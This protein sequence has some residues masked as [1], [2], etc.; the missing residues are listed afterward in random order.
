MVEEK[1]GPVNY[2]L[3]Q[4]GKHHSDTTYHVNLLKSWIES[5]PNPALLFSVWCPRPGHS[6]GRTSL[7]SPVQQQDLKELCS[8][9]A[10]VFSK[11]P[12]QTHV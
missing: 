3:Q 11:L 1:V 10:D 7:G 2:R 5:L 8:Q 12:R 4:S 6:L 9:H